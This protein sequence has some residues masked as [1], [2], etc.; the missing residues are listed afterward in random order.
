MEFSAE[1]N[2]ILL[3]GITWHLLLPGNKIFKILSNRVSGL[4]VQCLIHIE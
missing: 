4:K 1:R 2:Y 3:A